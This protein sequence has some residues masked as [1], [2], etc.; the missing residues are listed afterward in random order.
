MRYDVHTQMHPCAGLAGI[1]VPLVEVKNF[2]DK[3]DA[4]HVVLEREDYAGSPL[5]PRF[6]GIRTEHGSG[7]IDATAFAE[8]ALVKVK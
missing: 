5:I 4:R 1:V 6:M 7:R 8:T 3:A 2:D